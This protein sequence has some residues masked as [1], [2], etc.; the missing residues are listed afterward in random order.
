MRLFF[1]GSIVATLVCTVGAS[2]AQNDVRAGHITTGLETKFYLAGKPRAM[3]TLAD[4]MRRYRVPAVSIAVID[5][6]RVIWTYAAGFRDVASR[7]PATNGTLFQAASMSK[8]VAAAGI[9]R[10]FEEKHLSLDADVNTM[11]RSWHVP[12][13]PQKSRQR[14]T[15][16]RLLSHTAGINV[17][18][19][20]GYDRD[21]RLP[22]L[23]Q[24]LNGIPPAN[25]EPI[26]V[27]AVPGSATEYSGGGTS[28]AQQVAVD[29]S[30]QRFP[31]FMQDTLL[32]PL[33]MT[34][35]TFEQPLPAAL[36][37]RAANGYYADGK[38]V[39][40]GWH[41]YP[42]MAAA[43]LWTTASDLASF[44]IAIQNALRGQGKAPIDA[45][46][47]R[48]M[49]TKASQGFG[50]GPEVQPAYF[51]HNGANEGFQGIFLGLMHGGKGVVVMTNSD[52]GLSL[53]DEVLHAVAKAYGWSVLQPQARTAIGLSAAELKALAGTYA[54]NVGGERV[55]LQVSLHQ[56]AGAPALVLQSPLNF[57]E[58]RLY[59]EAPLRFF[60][61]SGGSL[62]FSRGAHGRVT[63]V[64]AAGA[65]FQRV[66]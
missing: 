51:S 44:V 8:P 43:G 35:S 64:Q 21:A 52:N 46:V 22:T 29:V 65:T 63:S 1:S 62:V 61:L 42:T 6:Y 59:A 57:G 40:R 19:F 25:S 11:L 41:V 10:L 7:S 37:L 9:L 15:M 56:S 28:I 38:A 48:E 33:A 12:P 16:R 4:E 60:T 55:A 49:T 23:V 31:A 13:P 5:R 54:A 39:H 50:L 45:T 34:S 3:R 26:R 14:V 58:E 24:V 17:H 32:A 66:P 36:W 2:A 30:R 53:A 20:T 18:G 27:T 47:A